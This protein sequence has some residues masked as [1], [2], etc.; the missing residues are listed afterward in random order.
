MVT[1]SDRAYDA[2]APVLRQLSVRTV[3]E[4]FLERG[5]VSRADL[6]KITGLS[7]QTTSEVIRQLEERGLVR[8]TGRAVGRVGRSAVTYELDASAGAVLGLDLG[9]TN[10]RLAL[11]DIKG[12]W[13]GE[14]ECPAD[15][16]GGR[17]VINQITALKRRLLDETG[18]A[19]GKLRR[20]A[21]AMPGV[22][23]PRTGTLSLAPNMVG[24]EG[25]DLLGTFREL[26]GCDVTIENDINSAAVGEFWRG[27]GAA[28]S[29]LAFV[30][31]GTGIGL[32]LLINGKL[33]RGATGA[34]GEISYL[35]FGTDPFAPLSL[36]R[37]ALECAIGAAGIAQRYV[38]A[39]GAPGT[40]VRDIVERS[41]RGD[42]AA[43]ATINETARIATLLIVTIQS[44]FDP[45]RIIIG[46]N[47]GRGA[48]MAALIRDT[49]PQC[50][51]RPIEI[52]ESLL[53]HRAPVIGAVAIALGHL[54][55]S[56]FSPQDL[57]GRLQLP[58]GSS[59]ALGPDPSQQQQRGSH[60]RSFS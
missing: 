3:I 8:P 33:L 54:H 47:I 4:V 37:G 23:D 34:A 24:V 9:A 19:P 36:E 25:I 43:R 1:G 35:P 6:A 44:M 12:G 49:L 52:E 2:D 7:K 10:I 18:V 51:R 21:V 59:S 11:A 39:G 45:E 40:S 22:V 57:P 42:G 20:A 5:A 13:V 50:S 46:G 16:R 48:D 56:L 32:G 15:R 28:A 60:I 30:S 17:A 41:R 26:L 38:M 53:G 27:H 29:S 14:L 55:E 58:N 31:L